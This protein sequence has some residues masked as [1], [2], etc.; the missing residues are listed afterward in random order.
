MRILSTFLQH[1]S[2]TNLNKDP[3][4]PALLSMHDNEWKVWGQIEENYETHPYEFAIAATFPYEGSA[5]TQ[6]MFLLGE[7][8]NFNGEGHS[9]LICLDVEAK[10]NLA[11]ENIDC[12]VWTASEAFIMLCK[13]SHILRPSKDTLWPQVRQCLS[14]ISQHPESGVRPWLPSKP[15]DNS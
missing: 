1:L 8:L 14:A 10:L 9:A 6:F 2:T 13:M 12:G 15:K 5:E 7:I 11:R 4:A 3:I